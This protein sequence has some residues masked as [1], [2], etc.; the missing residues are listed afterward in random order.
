MKE[1]ENAIKYLEESFCTSDDQNVCKQHDYNLT[2]AIKTMQNSVE[3]EPKIVSYNS[4]LY[5][6]KYK[7]C[8]ICDEHIRPEQK[9]CSNCGK[10]IKGAV[11]ND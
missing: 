4:G 5:D 8:P 3:V 10:K 11:I 2:V 9:Y 7:A 6:I 1:I